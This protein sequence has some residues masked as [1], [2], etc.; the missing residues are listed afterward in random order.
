MTP[1]NNEVGISNH[2]E[3]EQRQEEVNC[4]IYL[5][6]VQEEAMLLRTLIV[7]KTLSIIIER[8]REASEIP[9]N[10]ESLLH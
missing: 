1:K 8:K 9:A 6:Y 7:C 5:G 4:E 3:R 10:K 2:S